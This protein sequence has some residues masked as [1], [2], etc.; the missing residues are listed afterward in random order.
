[1]VLTSYHCITTQLSKYRTETGEHEEGVRFSFQVTWLQSDTAKSCRNSL[2]LWCHRPTR[3]KLD[4]ELGLL[5]EAVPLQCLDP[6]QDHLAP[7]PPAACLALINS[8]PAVRETKP[9]LQLSQ[10]PLAQDSAAPASLVC[11]NSRQPSWLLA[12]VPSPPLPGYFLFAL[13]LLGYISLLPSRLPCSQLLLKYLSWAPFTST[14]HQA[15]FQ[16]P[17]CLLMVGGRSLKAGRGTCFPLTLG[18][19]H[20]L[21]QREV[22]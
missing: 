13:Q 21:A 6:H 19:H 2:G 10:G 4:M 14:K 20:Y 17:V 5:P 12:T 9:R 3:N 11:P 8:P 18:S 15:H 22:Q 16:G 7:P 1:M